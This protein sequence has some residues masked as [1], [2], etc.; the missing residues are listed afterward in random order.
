MEI[1]IYLPQIG[2]GDTA[3]G[4]VFIRKILEHVPAEHTIH[5]H[6][7]EGEFTASFERE[8]VDIVSHH[9]LR[10]IF[11]ESAHSRVEPRSGSLPQTVESVADA[12]LEL[13]H[14]SYNMAK[15]KLLGSLG[16]DSDIIFSQYVLDTLLLSRLVDTPVVH[17]FHSLQQ[18]G[19]GTKAM[20]TLEDGVSYVANSDQTRREVERRL[21][22]GVDGIIYPGVDHDEFNPNVGPAMTTDVPT[23]LFVGRLTASKGLFDLLTSFAAVERPAHLYIAGQGDTASVERRIHDLGI[24]ASVTLLG[25]VA[26][27]ELPRYYSSCDIFCL[28]TYYETFGMANLEAMACG[29]PV[30]TTDIPGVRQYA[31]HDETSY[32][33]SPGDID[34]I[35]QGLDT[36]I[37]SPELRARLG[38]NGQRTAERYSWCESANR[39]VRV[40]KEILADSRRD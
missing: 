34:G 20:L 13:G 12:T 36:L 4:Y 40:S 23:V 9:R 2:T 22:V 8:N 18:V 31:T 16:E 17:I 11:P 30:L 24:D 6:T 10:D 33:V 15:S 1:G 25:T 7:V 29:T 21:G 28:P 39:M 26:H 32:L 19:A 38:N 14:S 27:D 5:L 35:T 37:S 3:G